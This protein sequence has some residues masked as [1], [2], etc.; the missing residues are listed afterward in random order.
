MVVRLFSSF[1]PSRVVVVVALIAVRRAEEVK[2]T[3][4]GQA[5]DVSLTPVLSNMFLPQVWL[6]GKSCTHQVLKN[7]SVELL[8]LWY[9]VNACK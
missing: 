3:P 1:F 6:P 8:R 2:R 4:Y 7:S 5:F 9:I